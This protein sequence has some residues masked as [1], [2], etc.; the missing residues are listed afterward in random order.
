[1]S[2]QQPEATAKSFNQMIKD[3]DVKRADSMKVRKE[4]FHEEPGF[5]WRIEGEDLDKS[6]EEIADFLIAGGQLPDLEVRPRDEGG[7]WIV[8]GHRRNRGYD[9]AIQRGAK[10][11]HLRDKTGQIWIGVK[12][13]LGNRLERMQRIESSSRNRQLSPLE[14]SNG[15]HEWR[16]AFQEEHGSLPSNDEIA[17]AFGK[18]R[19][20]V[21]Q[22]LLL[23]SAPEEVKAAVAAGEISATES[24]KLVREHG[25]NAAAELSERKRVASEIGKEKVTAASKKKPAPPSRPRVDMV[26]SNAVVLV[27]GLS[28]AIEAAVSD[29]LA[30]KMIEVS[31]DA[32]ADLIMAVREMQQAG[33]PLDADKQ[34][35]LFGVDA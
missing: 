20:H 15:Y 10:L 24:V 14:L 12:P 34:E 28:K 7:V 5:N 18:S 33:K 8:D 9:L 6:I 2:I 19:A 29:G 16:V 1:M 31:S 3:G 26:V 23:N 4:D 22:M 13:F 17:K 25:E 32:L 30:P 27:N 35:E 21:D 11:E